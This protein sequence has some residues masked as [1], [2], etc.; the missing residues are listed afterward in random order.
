MFP[1]SIKYLKYLQYSI[2]LLKFTNNRL[3][4]SHLYQD[5]K[6]SALW[7][8]VLSYTAIRQMNVHSCC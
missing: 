3:N 4:L 2:S 6:L 5:K 7:I 1:I 8:L